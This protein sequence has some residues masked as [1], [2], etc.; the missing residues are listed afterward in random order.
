MEPCEL[1]EHCTPPL[2]PSIVQLLLYT[3]STRTKR[4][5]SLSPSFSADWEP[6]FAE[7]PLIVMLSLYIA[8]H[9]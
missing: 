2:Y 1:A 3:T 4:S 8:S 6:G 5:F 7:L 9:P